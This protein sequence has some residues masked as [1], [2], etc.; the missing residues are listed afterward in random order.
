MKHK[1]PEFL[2]PA[3]EGLWRLAVWI[4]PGARKSE[5]AGAYQGRLKLRIQAPPVDGKANKAVQQFVAGLFGL[6]PSQVR[7][8]NGQTSR[9]KTLLLESSEEPAWQQMLS[10]LADNL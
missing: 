1:R 10:G 2:T 4:Q 6:R 7:L 9:G 5:V 3:G 8:E